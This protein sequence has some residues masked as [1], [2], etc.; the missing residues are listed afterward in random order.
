MKYRFVVKYIPFS[1]AN[2]PEKEDCHC[3]ETVT[4]EREAHVSVSMDNVRQQIA[5]E[6][7]E[8]HY[9]ILSIEGEA[10]E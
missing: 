8:Q 4:I 1:E 6:L 10:L 5:F 2:N 9:R 7:E 3:L